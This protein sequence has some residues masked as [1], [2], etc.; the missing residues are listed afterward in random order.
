[1][2]IMEK[3][4]VGKMQQI[5]FRAMGSQMLAAVDS[6]AASGAESLVSI[7]QRFAD[8]ERSLSRF[9][10]ESELSKLNRSQGRPVRV[11]AVLWDVVTSA[12]QA[13]QLTE[14]LVT[15]AVLPALEESGYTRSFDTLETDIGV[16][17]RAV[18]NTLA[19]ANWRSIKL[20][21]RARSIFLPEGLRIDLG[22]IAKGWAAD[23]AAEEL[24]KH[25]PALVDAGGDIAVSG[26]MADG[27]AWP[28][29]VADPLKEGEQIAL[30]MLR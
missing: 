15:P 28:I 8:W 13:A 25:G 23:R 20:D 9:L 17:P 12:L 18:A 3:E 26:P 7:P 5:T 6:S 24:G 27:S 19:V 21:P 10:E 22:G 14:G 11:S 4:K 16:S 30:I 29:G 1:M 2:C